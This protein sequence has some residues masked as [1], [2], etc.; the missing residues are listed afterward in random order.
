MQ[1]SIYGRKLALLTHRANNH[2]QVDTGIV[3]FLHADLLLDRGL[4]KR[5]F[6]LRSDW[7]SRV[8]SVDRSM[9][10]RCGDAEVVLALHD[11]ELSEQERSSLL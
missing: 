11:A 9:K 1:P 4:R 10:G 6:R 3:T 7:M 2:V 8:E 5:P